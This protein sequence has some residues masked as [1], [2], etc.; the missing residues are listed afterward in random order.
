MQPV[1]LQRRQGL[2]DR[3]SSCLKRDKLTAIDK[4]LWDTDFVETGIQREDTSSS[5]I[6]DTFHGASPGIIGIQDTCC[7]HQA[8][9]RE[10][11][12]AAIP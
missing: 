2:E 1:A 8:V 6:L 3:A 9:T 12:A 10:P 5:E 7:Y 4:L 11:A